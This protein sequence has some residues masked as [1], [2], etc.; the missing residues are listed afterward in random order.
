[1]GELDGFAEVQGVGEALLEVIND[2]RGDALA[3]AR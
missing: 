3:A 1:M 2:I